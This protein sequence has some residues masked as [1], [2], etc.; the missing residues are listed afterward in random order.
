MQP[1]HVESAAA[2]QGGCAGTYAGTYAAYMQA[3][4]HACRHARMQTRTQHA[5]HSLDAPMA[6]CAASHTDS[7]GLAHASLHVR[8][9]TCAPLR[10]AGSDIGE[11][12][13]PLLCQPEAHWHQ[14]RAQ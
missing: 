3:C 13:P 5:Q 4:T 11:R 14:W 12:V 10:G 8:S 1:A 7:V 9:I 2:V 6:A